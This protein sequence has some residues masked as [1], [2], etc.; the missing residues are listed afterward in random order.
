MKPDYTHIS[1]IID[2]SGSMQPLVASTISGFGKLVEE[3]KALPGRVDF[4]LTM[5][6]TEVSTYPKEDIQIVPALS[7]LVYRPEGGTALLDALGATI[8]GLGEELSA[9][10]EE[11]RPSKVIVAVITDGE[12]NSSRIYTSRQEVA[13][14]IKHQTEV[15]GW[16]FIFIGAN[17][18]AVAEATSLNIPAAN[19]ANY[20]ATDAGVA[21]SYATTSNIMSRIR[22]N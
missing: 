8:K 19:A 20:A 14:M 10:P 11:D 3:Q 15:Y 2:R 7:P 1:C 12:E 4:Q 21:T 18:D 13:D 22:G 17:M 6:N 9:M 5:F 16:E